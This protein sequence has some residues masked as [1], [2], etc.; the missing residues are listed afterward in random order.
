MPRSSNGKDPGLLIQLISVR[1]RGEVPNNWG[2]AE[3][4]RHLPLKQ[5]RLVQL[6]HPQPN[7]W[8]IAQLVERRS[9]TP[10]V[11]GSIPSGPAKLLANTLPSSNGRAVALHATDGSSILSGSTNFSI[12]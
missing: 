10:K 3:R 7:N 6:Q 5:T 11:E 12:G 4:H 9:L 2:L 8:L 1:V